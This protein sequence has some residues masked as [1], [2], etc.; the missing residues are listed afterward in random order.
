MGRYLLTHLKK[1]YPQA[2]FLEATRPQF[3]LGNVDALVSRLGGFEPDLVFHLAGLSRVRD[4]VPFTEYFE[5]NFLTTTNLVKALERTGK[6]FKMFFSS[7]IHVYGP[8]TEVVNEESAAKPAS[9]YGFSKYLAEE[10]LQ[11]LCKRRSDV[12]VTVGRLYNCLGPGQAPGFV[13]ADWCQKLRDLP[14][15]G[16]VLKVGSLSSFRYFID[17]RDAVE[18]FPQLLEKAPAGFSIYNISSQTPTPLEDILKK[19]I[20]VSGKHP[21]IEVSDQQTPN[22]FPGLKISTA[23]LEAALP[24][25]KL[26]PLDETLREMYAERP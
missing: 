25:T 4:D 15:D 23:K 12:K 26:R 22:R 8:Q 7:S 16:G 21:K 24:G 13:A 10:A 6:P 18:M 20:E 5:G 9:P 2:V 11:D 17:V 3:D 14:A 19:L 1:R